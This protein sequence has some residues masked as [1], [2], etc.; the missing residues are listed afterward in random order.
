MQTPTTDDAG[1]ARRAL[2]H[3]L[4]QAGDPDAFEDQGRLERRQHRLQRRARGLLLRRHRRVLRPGRIG[5][6]AR[7]IDHDVGAELFGERPARRRIICGDDRVQS[8][9]LQRRDDREPDRAA[10]DHQRH[11]VAANIGLGHGVNA[12]RERFGQR[13]ML[14]RKA[15]R[16]YEQQRFAE[17]H[18]L[19]IAADM[20]VGIADAFGPSAV[21]SA[22]S[23]QTRVPGFSLRWVSGP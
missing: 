22:G 11:L 10:A 6:R 13:R 18:A 23:E 17:Q 14:R 8:S 21:S 20:V 5:L 1:V 2:E 15:V 19:G 9:E 4:D 12:D 7:G 16:H 3:L